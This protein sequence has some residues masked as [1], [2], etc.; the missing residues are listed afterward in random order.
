MMC[1]QNIKKTNEC[2]RGITAV[3]SEII[4]TQINCDPEI[5]TDSIEV[6]RRHLIKQYAAIKE[7]M[8]MLQSQTVSIMKSFKK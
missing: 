4:N 3:P 7:A 8:C 1:D 2:Q 6:Q 5:S